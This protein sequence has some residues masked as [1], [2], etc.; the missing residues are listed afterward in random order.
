MVHL[1]ALIQ[2]IV[3]ELLKSILVNW[4]LYMERIILCEKRNVLIIKIKVKE[5]CASHVIQ[6][7]SAYFDPKK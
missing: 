3:V 6:I 1:M 2:H 5:I 7:K 4:L